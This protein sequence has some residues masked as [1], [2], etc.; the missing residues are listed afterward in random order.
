MGE[1][2]WRHEQIDLEYTR[3]KNSQFYKNS[4][5]PISLWITSLLCSGN[6]FPWKTSH[7]QFEVSLEL[8][9]YRNKQIFENTSGHLK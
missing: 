8:E 6:L 9:I 3:L 1:Q 2:K 7:C 5:F 4:Q